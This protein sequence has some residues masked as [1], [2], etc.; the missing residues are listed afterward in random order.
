MTLIVAGTVRV[1][2]EMID[3]FR[4]YMQAMIEHSRGEDGC[5]D[6]AYAQDVIDP[7]L[8][9]VFE[10]WRDRAALE[11]HFASPHLAEWRAAWGQFG[12]SDRQLFAYEVASQTLV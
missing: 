8:I 11:Q 1:P 7:G 6:Y 10:V 2:P 4:P 3:T 5:I 12:V 9:R